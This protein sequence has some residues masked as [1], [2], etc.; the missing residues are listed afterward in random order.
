[1]R[2][3]LFFMSLIKMFKA[4]FTSAPRLTPAECAAR[5]RGGEAILV[6]VREPNE[7]TAGVAQSAK[8]LPLSDL[9]GARTQW[10]LFLAEAAD[11][12]ILLYCAAGGRS[13]IA[14]RLLTA[15]GFRAVNT[16]SFSDWLA[17]GWPV[18]KPANRRR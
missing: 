11:R 10:K 15:E 9:T 3:H 7:W 1:M 4:M 18:A 8:L 14:A 5:V 2:R 13:G 12:E 16:G 17:S 6:D